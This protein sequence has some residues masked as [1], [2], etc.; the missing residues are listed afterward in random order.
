MPNSKETRPG[1]S[2]RVGCANDA[3]SG[4]LAP[5]KRTLTEALPVVQ[6]KP[7]PGDAGTAKLD[8]GGGG[9][10]DAGVT[11]WGPTDAGTGNTSAPAP[12]TANPPPSPV[13]APPTTES[14]E[15]RAFVVPA[16][17]QQVQIYVSAGAITATPDVFMF[18][19]GYFANYGIDK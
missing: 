16:R 6:R 5:G 9:S 13:A 7:A 19:H 2:T 10:A 11:A 4:A 14:K 8:D 12:D 18:F 15:M 3:T 17:G 1:A